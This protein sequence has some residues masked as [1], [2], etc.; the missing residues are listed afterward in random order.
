MTKIYLIAGESSG[1]LLGSRLMQSLQL[2]ITAEFYGI[3]GPLMTKQG[4]ESLFPIT[5]INLIG[6]VEIIPHI[7]RIKK[8]L[9]YAVDDILAINPDLLIT[10]DSP[11]FTCRVA[12]AIRQSRPNLKIVHIVAPSV[13]AYKPGRALKYAKIYDYL[14]ALLPFEPQFFE[15][16]G[17]SCD[18]IGL[19]ILEQ[20]FYQDQD[21]QLLR[22]QL[23]LPSGTK[24]ISVT[25][26]SRESEIIRHMPAFCQALNI[27]SQTV[28]LEVIFVI[29]RDQHQDLIRRFLLTAKFNFRFSRQHLKEFAR[30]DVALAKSG[31]STL[32]IAASGTSMVVAYKL[33]ILS[34]WWIKLLIKVRWASLINI[35]A[36]CEILPE[37]IQSNCRPQLLAAALINLLLNPSLAQQQVTSSQS[38]LSRLGFRSAQQPSKLA[39]RL[40]AEKILPG[41]AHYTP[42]NN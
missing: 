32:E 37:F 17:L 6:F 11:G 28:T 34:F 24:I 13:W 4:L 25:A 30:A 18:Y 38:I 23:Q 26:G 1:D 8:L 7:W 35:V 10:I 33:N 31:I 29:A 36:D 14:L 39:A 20:E 3:G 12:K 15:K 21:K 2:I 9:K 40:I 42:A 19:P 16:V 22:S 27:V 5:A 41:Q